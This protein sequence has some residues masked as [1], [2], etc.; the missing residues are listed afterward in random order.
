MQPSNIWQITINGNL[1][2][3]DTKLFMV[4]NFVHVPVNYALTSD[5]ISAFVKNS[6][7]D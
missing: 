1:I 6:P 3:L 4:P 7:Q 5:C 2:V